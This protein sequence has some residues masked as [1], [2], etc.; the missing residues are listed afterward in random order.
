MN[1]L[2]VTFPLSLLIRSGPVPFRWKI[3]KEFGDVPFPLIEECP[4]DYFAK[5]IEEISGASE[6][7]KSAAHSN[8]EFPCDSHHREIAARQTVEQFPGG[9]SDEI[10][11][12]IAMK[13][14][15]NQ[16]QPKE[17]TECSDRR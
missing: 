16:L 1:T 17:R 4:G 15:E 6:L 7:A 8:W 11:L 10:V 13:N 12:G 9:H 3:L 5:I 14:E 2:V